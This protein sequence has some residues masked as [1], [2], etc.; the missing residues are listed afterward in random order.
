MIFDKCYKILVV[1][2][3][4]DV[5]M[6]LSFD[7]KSAD[8]DVISASSGEIAL[9]ILELTEI[10]LIIL[11]MNMPGLSGLSTLERLKANEHWLNIPVIMLST[12]DGEDDVVSALDL[13]A[14][15]YVVKPYIKKVLF[16]RIRTAI[17]LREKTKAL[18]DLTKT[19][20]LTGINNRACFEELAR[21]AISQ[22]Q[23]SEQALVMAM[24]DIDLFK[25]VND[26]YGHDIG[27]KVL[28]AFAQSLTECFRR[29]D[30][31]ARIGGEEF[32]VCLP[33]T[34]VDDA[35]G[36]CER[37]RENI[38]HMKIPLNN[39]L[40]KAISVTTSVGIASSTNNS[41]DLAC[42]LK[43]ADIGL[44]YAK[45]HGRNRLI[46]ADELLDD[47][48]VTIGDTSV[49]PVEEKDLIDN[50][51]SAKSSN[52]NAAFT[53]KGIDVVLGIGNVLGDEQLY[54]EI[55]KIFYK[56]HHN[57]A[58][59]LVIAIENNDIDAAKHLAH[60]LKGVASSVGAM[61]LF[62]ATKR[63]DLAINE[64]RYNSITL[65]LKEVVT[66]VEIVM[67]SLNEHLIASTE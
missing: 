39:G 16:A 20:F 21:S 13:G 59:K 9:S 37:F 57:D 12:S 47:D 52:V 28:V 23:R 3:A 55:L 63:L 29:Y 10:D 26:D 31:V 46:N 4:K 30:I 56:D 42:L 66:E 60:T 24:F 36:T 48:I 18:E 8:C 50:I 61:A 7:L 25:L 54:K 15:D 22:A 14:N 38:E 40:E 33:N 27:D 41:L 53:I 34:S 51:E 6:L 2:D 64:Q 1:D 45:S 5:Q 35:I 49:Y 67:N 62:E 43:Q 44:Y 58:E 17:R 65:L 32:A 11:D 19:D